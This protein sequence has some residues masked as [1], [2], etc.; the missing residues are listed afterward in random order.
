MNEVT[1]PLKLTGVG[2]MKA[3]LRQL[4]AEIAA[5]TDPAQMEMLA[6][7][8][9]ELSD[10]IKDANDAVNV[11]AS[12]SKFEQISN[13]FDGIKSSLMSLDFAEASEKSQV[14][15]S[16][17]GKIGKADI[18]GAIKGITGTIKTLGGAFVKLGIQ[19]LANP[20]FLLVAVIVAIVAGIAVFLSSIGVLQKAFDFLM[21]PINAIIDG[22][23]EMT[24][25]LGLTQYA[26]EENAEKVGKANEKAAE[27][28]KKRVEKITDAYDIEINKAKAAGKDTTELEI[29]KS[30]AIS[31]E[32]EGRLKNNREELAALQKVASKDNL[33]KRKKLREQI[34]AE[35]K[36]LS[37]GSKERQIM[38]DNDD[39]EQA[40][41]EKEN[42]AKR[43]EKAKEYA[44]NRF[45]A[46]RTIKD[47]E[48]SLIVDDAKR[49][50]EINNEKYRRLIEDV[51]KNENLTGAEKVRLTK[52]YNDQKQAELD[53][54]ALVQA[55]AEK[56]RQA[57][58]AAG[59]KAFNEAEADKAEEIQEQLYQ[60]S[61][62]EQQRELETNKYHYDALIAEAQRYGL[63]AAVLIEEQR[64]KEAEINKKYDDA[65]RQA[66][67]AKIEAEKQVRD[68]KIQAA[69][70]A[71]QGLLNL[72]SLVVKD[73]KKL[74]QINKASALVQIGIDTAKAISSLVAAA[75]ANPFN[76]ISA[77]AAG[78]AQFASGILQIT[79]NMVKAKQLL[80]N[81]SGNVSGGGG[82]S[83]ASSSSSAAAL[84]PQVN[85]FGQ[86]NNLN[87]AGQLKSAN[88]TPS[89]VVQA[90]V[91][92]TDITNTQS[93]INKIKQGSEL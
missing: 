48:L 38:R 43:K 24:D 2:S 52:L 81:P 67:L 33:E 29:A 54:A 15:A 42:E 45:D 58:I 6:K 60:A 31:K 86:G 1:I 53:K 71:A 82:G 70:D 18:S 59:I 50:E 46:Q 34:D 84:V 51:K 87:T 63:D 40:Q 16:N 79:T 30:K 37:D 83:T 23:K 91:S 49:E 47:I 9:G 8:A 11:F 68:A 27:S 57:E 21:I 20:I 61:L 78:I 72:T 75:N 76:G 3:E 32:A 26:A 80:S 92:E 65:E 66:Q 93:K 14:F 35:K 19:I 69:G 64:A 13:S 56:K 77:G 85:L 10:R 25:W 7:K 36:I 5:A 12:G 41:K 88:A 39:A 89:F 73:Q 22:F 62:T 44:K 55:E 90:V 17:L 4:K 74:E 28:S